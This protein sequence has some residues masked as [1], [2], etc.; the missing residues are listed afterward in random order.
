MKSLDSRQWN[1]CSSMQ[2]ITLTSPNFTQ[3]NS[4]DFLNEKFRNQQK[5]LFTS[6]IS[7]MLSL[8]TNSHYNLQSSCYSTAGIW[9]TCLL[10]SP[11]LSTYEC[12]FSFHITTLL[13]WQKHYS[14]H[15]YEYYRDKQQQRRAQKPFHRHC[16]LAG[17]K[18]RRHETGAPFS[19]VLWSVY[20]Q[21]FSTVCY[22]SNI[23]E[24]IL[25]RNWYKSSSRFK[26]Y[27][28]V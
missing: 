6:S 1:F 15:I 24:I 14:W 3:K 28:H 5:F 26:H 23:H 20:Q 18:P 13:L 7:K 2:V 21:S 27:Q 4:T 19:V 16:C 8:W 22:S 25:H 12:I 10:I 17:K 11:F 9:A